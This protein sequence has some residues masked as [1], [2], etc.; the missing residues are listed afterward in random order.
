MT[1]IVTNLKCQISTIRFRTSPDTFNIAN[2]HM[3][4]ADRKKGRGGGVAMYINFQLKYKIRKDIYIDGIENL[5]IEIDNKYGKNIIVGTLYRPPSNNINNFID[6]LD[7]ELDKMSRENKHI[8]IMGDFNIDLSKSLQSTPPHSI[9]LNGNYS[10]DHNT[11][12]F[13]NILSSYGF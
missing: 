13:L 8:Y 3:I 1:V 9:L 10:I 4:H 5:F 7:E 12:A 6:K 2:Y 11:N